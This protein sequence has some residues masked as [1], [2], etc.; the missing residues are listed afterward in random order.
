MSNTNNVGVEVC[1]PTPMVFGFF[2]PPD[3]PPI[4]ET[5]LVFQRH[6][7]VATLSGRGDIKLKALWSRYGKSTR[8]EKRNGGKEIRPLDFC[9]WLKMVVVVVCIGKKNLFEYILCNICNLGAWTDENSWC[10][11]IRLFFWLY[12]SLSLFIGMQCIYQ[13]SFTTSSPYC[14]IPCFPLLP[15]LYPSYRSVHGHG[16]YSA[17]H[18]L[19]VCLVFS[20]PVVIAT[21]KM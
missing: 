8:P 21:P 6:V 2:F 18:Q 3:L 9:W 5:P 11:F 10:F 7:S 19:S 1:V 12:H 15:Y 17:M 20:F 4:L 14:P 16:K 13:T